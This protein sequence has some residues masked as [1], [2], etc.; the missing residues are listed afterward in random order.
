MRRQMVIEFLELVRLITTQFARTI[1]DSLAMLKYSMK[2][3]TKPMLDLK[4]IT[5]A[6]S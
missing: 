4:I 1:I 5:A 6:L 2:I 3:L